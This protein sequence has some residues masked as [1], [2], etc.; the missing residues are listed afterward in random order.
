[1]WDGFCMDV[2]GSDKWYSFCLL[3]GKVD[4]FWLVVV[5][6]FIDVFFFV[7]LVKLF[8]GEL[9]DSYYLFLGGIGFCV[10]I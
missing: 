2:E 1:M 10:L 9:W 8:G 3:V 5:E 7:I 4:C 6:S